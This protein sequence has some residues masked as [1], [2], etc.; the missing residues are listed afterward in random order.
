MTCDKTWRDFY[1]ISPTENAVESTGVNTSIS[2]K[3][4]SKSFLKRYKK[5]DSLSGDCEERLQ[6]KL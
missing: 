2:A 4:I 5:T 1:C 3:F 6:N